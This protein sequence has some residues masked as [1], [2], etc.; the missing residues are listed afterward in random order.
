MLL[1]YYEQIIFDIMIKFKIIGWFHTKKTHKRKGKILLIFV[2]I[3]ENQTPN[4]WKRIIVP[5]IGL[6]LQI[7]N[8]GVLC[9][10]IFQ[11]LKYWKIKF[12]T[13]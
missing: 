4:L 9:I 12:E 8:K 6:L 1:E 10:L 5:T 11:M 3:V 2:K 7:Y 13:T